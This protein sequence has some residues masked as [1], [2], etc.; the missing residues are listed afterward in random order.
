MQQQT[1]FG[2]AKHNPKKNFFKG[3]TREVAVKDM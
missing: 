3:S 1:V 2:Q